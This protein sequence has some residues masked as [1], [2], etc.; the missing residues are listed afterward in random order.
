MKTHFFFFVVL[1][2]LSVLYAY[3][4]EGDRVNL[5]SPEGMKKG[6]IF[7]A[8]ETDLSYHNTAAVSSQIYGAEIY[9]TWGNIE[10]SEG[11]YDWSYI[12]NFISKY[13]LSGKK[14][15][16]RIATANF[17]INDSPEY[18]YT[19]YNIRRIVSGYWDNF[20]KGDKGYLIHGTKTTNSINGSYS[21]H[22]SSS[23]RQTIIE[24]GSSHVYDIWNGITN[25]TFNPTQPV[26][27][28]RSPGFCLQFDFKTNSGTTF[29]AKAYSRSTPK[30]AADSVYWT[31][32]AGESGSKTFQFYP[33]NFKTDY[34]IE[35]GIVT[36]N[37]TIDNVN[38]CDMK[39]AYYVGTLCFPNYFDPKFKE[40]YEVFV[41]ALANR[42][43][44]ETT[45]NSICIGGYGRW[46]EITLSDDVEPYRFEDQWTTFGFSNQ[47]YID[48]IKWCIQL[49]KKHFTTKRLYMG[50]VGWNTD[51]Y[52]D[53]VMI[54][55]KIGGYAAKQGIGIKYNGWQAMCGDWGSPA[56]GFFYLANRYKFDKSVWTMFEEGGQINNTGLT[57]IMGHPISL[58]NRASIDGIDYNWM[59]QNDLQELYINRYFQYANQTA[60]SGLFTKMYNL[61]G[62]HPYYSPKSNTLSNLKNIWMGVFQ[63]DLNTGTKWTYS[64]I[65]GVKVVQTNPG[66]NR[67]TFSIDDRQKY[68]GMYGAKLNLEYL[69]RGTDEFSIYGNLPNGLTELKRIRKTNTGQW[70]TVEVLDNGWTIKEG[71]K[72]MDML[73]ELEIDDRNDGVETFRMLE[74]EYVPALEWQERIIQSNSLV[75]GKSA[76][77]SSNVTVNITN[78]FKVGVSGI[79]LNISSTSS[80]YVNVVADVSAL[81]NGN[82]ISI[83]KKE[84]HMPDTEDWF[85][86]PMAKHPLADAYRILLRSNQ[87][88]ATV[89]LGADNSAAYRLYSFESEAGQRIEGNDDFQIEALKPFAQLQISGFVN[90]TLVLKKKML[91]GNFVQVASVYVNATGKGFVEPQTAGLYNITTENGQP[92]EAIPDYLKRLSVPTAPIRDVRG[93]LVKSLKGADALRVVS[94][95]KNITNGSDGFKAL[96]SDKNPMIT[97]TTALNLTSEDAT[98]F[99][100][101]IKNETGASLSKIYWKTATN[102][103][104]EEN[105]MIMPIVP[106]DTEF[107]E[108]SYPMIFEAGWT[109]IIEGIRFVP[110]F[111]N[112]TTGKIA[113][114][115]LELRKG[116]NLSSTISDTLNI[117]STDFQINPPMEIVTFQLNEGASFTE[118]NE[119][120]ISSTVVNGIPTHYKISETSRFENALWK[121]YANSL[122][123]YFSDSFGTKTVFFKVK[124]DYSESPAVSASIIYK[125]P[126]EKLD[127]SLRTHISAFPNPVQ[128]Y[129]KFDCTENENERFE[130]SVI[131]LSGTICKQSVETGNFNLDVSDCPKGV[132]LVRIANERG[133]S[134]KIILKN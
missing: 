21:V 92:V 133:V 29:Y 108:Y 20:E 65:D 77:L 11:V 14:V 80:E 70:K 54:D 76:S 82:Y 52:R 9:T 59:Y 10:K 5:D 28:F 33:K 22:M 78:M 25:P 115:S 119:V 44:D 18:L 81:I 98:V 42:Y 73:N 74:I 17:S 100:F 114:H 8:P 75:S 3:S 130:V 19:R 13:K 26:H 93:T 69:D 58:L 7:F 64:T 121:E 122:S 68:N 107:R 23:T 40:R 90:T 57:E 109:G 125:T 61:F 105:S 126:T 129:V 84:Y 63:N 2:H 104:S 37:L 51:P 127:A 30:A 43:K 134:Q 60:G 94:G 79:A 53:Q 124:D 95:L 1:F 39:T 56:V 113:I 31:V 117:T 91:S 48:H 71:Q 86:I 45:L 116:T 97:T 85:Y 72:G 120:K 131:T 62:T 47:N 83:G 46:E 16:L 89:Q 132:L 12:D 24:S 96:L 49:Y 112:T 103:Y 111:G 128:S 67:I 66:N 35:I 110:V 15:A 32:L 41:Q 27:K 123:Y 88:N 4:A 102:D 50:A 6:T 99:K 106:N 87:G 101:V 38:V 55:W 118:K 34:K 36:G